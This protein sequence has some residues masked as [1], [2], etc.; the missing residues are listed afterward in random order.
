MLNKHLLLLLTLTIPLAAA[1]VI[2]ENAA[3]RASFEPE[4]PYVLT[5]LTDKKLGF[6]HIAADSLSP[7]RDSIWTLTLRNAPGAQEIITPT[8]AKA[9]SH[10][11]QGNTLRITWQGLTGKTIAAN[12]DFTAIA[13]LRDNGA[14]AWTYEVSGTA[15]GV[16]WE[17]SY[18]RIRA[19]S[20]L[21]NDFLVTPIYLGRLTR[22]PAKN[23]RNVRVNYPQ[24]GSMQFY[25][26]WSTRDLRQ[27]EL[28]DAPVHGTA[29]T[30]W[31]PDQSDAAGLLYHVEDPLGYH[32][33][34][35]AETTSIPGRLCLT[36]TNIPELDVWPIPETTAQLPVAYKAPYPVLVKPFQGDY[37]DA[38][39]EYFAWARQQKW[40]AAGP[41]GSDSPQPPTAP[42][43]LSRWKP[44]WFRNAGFW[45]K[46]Y[47]EPYKVLGEWDAYQDWLRLPI[48]S[49]YYR[50]NIAR[51]DDNYPE[52]LPGDSYLLNGMQIAKAMNIFPMPYING[53]IWDDDT[54]SWFRE[55]GQAA[56]VA[57]ESGKYPIWDINKEYFAYMC[58]ATAQWQAKMRETT[59]KQ[60]AEHGMRGVYLDCL[61]ATASRPCYNP[62]HGHPIRGGHYQADG[63]RKLMQELRRHIRQFDPYAA[64]FTEGIGEMYLDC[65]DGFLTLDYTR[66]SLRSGEQILPVF[67]AVYN[68]YAI[69]FGS[70][71]SLGMPHDAFALQMGK[72][73]TWGSVPLL[74]ASVALPPQPG[75][76]SA[77]L[78]R[79]ITRA[80]YLVSRSLTQSA[81]WRRL[82]QRPLNSDAP[83]SCLDVQS[84]SH[85]V[86][87]T[88][89]A[90]RQRAWEGPAV[91]AGA[92]GT[93]DR[94]SLLL[95]NVTDQPQ[96]A[97]VTVGADLFDGQPAVRGRN[98]WP[99][100]TSIPASGAHSLTLAPGKVAILAYDRTPELPLPER[101]PL[102][103]KDWELLMVSQDG[104]F[105]QPEV[106]EHSMWSCPDAFTLKPANSNKIQMLVMDD[107]GAPIRRK[108]VIPSLTGAKTEGIGM[109][110]QRLEQPFAIIKKLPHT[111]NSKGA[112]GIVSGGDAYFLSVLFPPAGEKPQFQTAVPG[113]FVSA[114]VELEN[115]S[116]ATAV[117]HANSDAFHLWLHERL[118]T[119]LPANQAVYVGFANLDDDVVREAERLSAAYSI[120]VE[121]LLAACREMTQTPTLAALSRLNLALQ[122]WFEN[123]SP[124]P[125]LF[126]PGR[127]GAEIFNRIQALTSPLS[128]GGDVALL[129][130]HDWLAPGID[131]T[132]RA[133]LPDKP[134][135]KG[136]NLS[137]SALTDGDRKALTL[138][139]L[140]DGDG[141]KVLLSEQRYVE[142]LL[143][144]AAWNKIT[145]AG[146]V[147]LPADLTWL[148]VNRPYELQTQPLPAT[149]VTDKQ[150]GASLNLRNWS[151]LDLNIKTTVQTPAG[152]SA[153]VEP[154][155][156]RVPA[157]SDRKVTIAV[158]APT[159]THG[160]EYLL[161]ITTNH[162]DA[163]DAACLGTI[164]VNLVENLNP[165][166]ASTPAGFK[167]A[168]PPQLRRANILA[169]HA[170][171]G[172][173]VAITIENRRVT[174]YTSTLTWR[175]LDVTMQPIQEKKL[176][177]DKTFQLEFTAAEEGP[178]YLEVDAQQGSAVVTSNTHVLSEGATSTARLNLFC[179][180]I[181]RYFYVPKDTRAFTFF[182]KDGGIDET[183]EVIITSPTGR[184]VLNRDGNW[185]SESN[186][187]D[188]QA[189]ESGSVWSII[190]RPVQ[191]VSIWL[192]NDASPW[193]APSPEAVLRGRQ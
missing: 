14:L 156:V 159:N 35:Y 36:V 142:R 27:P 105:P 38:A 70:D 80:Y 171:K 106:P 146:H 135:R 168:A 11:T 185:T 191:D 34:M 147:F 95:V 49:H 133:A 113:V 57:D 117:F 24:S 86:D 41:I 100:P 181:T 192:N 119:P 166:A 184:V 178:F 15:N 175:L 21:G 6:N 186:R 120:P 74:S 123:S 125:A 19:I 170:R 60:V 116:A 165:V 158:T 55:N 16:L 167:D 76:R 78:L 17:V 89:L 73:F 29:E 18:P 137:F 71:A 131:K 111:C 51:F 96:T 8:Q 155:S 59:W 145:V 188:V 23:P 141:V 148:E 164:K 28:P 98:L 112:L 85:R 32:K 157:L 2:L 150:A 169:G 189:G 9:V 108:G 91:V 154:Q 99:E 118:A 52:H 114:I 153:S 37:H 43:D 136:G 174:T 64:F 132:I 82:S 39:K 77:E 26:Y 152:W 33:Q 40:C 22:N 7:T 177:V 3:T 68:S 50:Y 160:G 110:R 139:P 101:L 45:A 179:S 58:P 172:E 149:L 30:G 180:P 42:D 93:P 162:L 107:K 54:Q 97:I 1:P 109:P 138:T 5:E 46:F 115:P 127:P 94:V 84:A 48:A 173:K 69:N 65:M 79:E 25:A 182:A 134:G 144:L 12:L 103:E 63:N 102:L 104:D 121:P 187:I 124:C 161:N 143:P 183:A 10:Q 176:A 193:L 44:E 163:P 92:F 66:S 20:N 72:L 126:A 81:S 75:D 190:C 61:A 122:Q 87:Y 56:A 67:N 83:A 13:T 129:P 151:P 47:F 53:V 88:A 130:E 31:Y 140:P 90:K 128:S 62:D 4:Q